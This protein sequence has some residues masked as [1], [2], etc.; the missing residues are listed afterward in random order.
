MNYTH[1]DIKK[2]YYFLI[3]AKPLVN[4]KDG[5]ILVNRDKSLEFLMKY[6]LTIQ[7]VKDTILSLTCA[8]YISGPEKDRDAHGSVWIF[9]KRIREQN[10]LY[11]T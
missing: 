2:P 7:D 1:D 10:N 5:F 9:K 3:Q 8:D 11:K 4:I 6:G